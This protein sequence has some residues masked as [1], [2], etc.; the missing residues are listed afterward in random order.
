MSAGIVLFSILAFFVVNPGWFLCIVGAI[1]LVCIACAVSSRGEKEKR[2]HRDYNAPL[3]DPNS[4]PRRNVQQRST[5]TPKPRTAVPK[6]RAST[7]ENH[8]TSSGFCGTYGPYSPYTNHD[9][10]KST[11]F[12]DDWPKWPD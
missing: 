10:N 1:V 2:A 8:L 9:S 5:P 11:D 7:A 4:S 6:Q 3:Y 12:L